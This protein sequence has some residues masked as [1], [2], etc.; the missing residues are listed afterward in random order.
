[1]RHASIPSIIT[2][3][4]F[5]FFFH[6]CQMFDQEVRI[7]RGSRCRLRNHR[8]W[9]NIVQVIYIEIHGDFIHCSTVQYEQY[10]TVQYSTIISTGIARV[11]TW[12]HLNIRWTIKW[13]T[14]LWNYSNNQRRRSKNLNITWEKMF[15]YKWRYWIRNAKKF[16]IMTSWE[17]FLKKSAGFEKHLKNLRWIYEKKLF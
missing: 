4:V 10:S 3:L 13:W 9:R 5:N 15:L 11:L 8:R 2:F 14:E 7:K 12:K 1:M 6:R 17:N 16:W